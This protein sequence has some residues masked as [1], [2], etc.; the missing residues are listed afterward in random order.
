MA[1][2]IPPGR[3]RRRLLLSAGA[4]LVVGLV[5]GAVLGRTTAPTVEDRVRDVQDSAASAVAQLE[6]LPTEYGQL[7][8]GGTEFDQGG[9]VD[10]A[11]ARTRRE[12]D[13]AIADAPWVSA[14]EIDDL[15]AAIEAIRAG[16]DERVSVTE[17]EG[18]I[19]EAGESISGAFGTPRDDG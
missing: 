13:G 6:A 10:D 8:A 19:A 1:M 18:L 9:G 14:T 3:R 5:I 17:L 16:A 2:Y 7:L 11:L 4:A 12:I 15:H